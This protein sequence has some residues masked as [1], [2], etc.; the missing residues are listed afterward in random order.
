VFVSDEDETF[1]YTAAPQPPLGT[2]LK[3]NVQF[4]S[5]EIM[6]SYLAQADLHALTNLRRNPDRNASEGT[7]PATALP[8]ANLHYDAMDLKISGDIPIFTLS[9]HFSSEGSPVYSTIP[10]H[11]EVSTTATERLPQKKK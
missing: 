2:P 10:F 9:L 7:D 1:E 5:R 3:F 4:E 8:P 6:V 11:V